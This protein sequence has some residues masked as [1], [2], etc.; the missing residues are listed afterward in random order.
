MSNSG[1]MSISQL[2]KNIRNIVE[3]EGN[4]LNGKVSSDVLKGILSKIEQSGVYSIE[5]KDEAK[6]VLA[7]INNGTLQSLNGNLNWRNVGDSFASSSVREESDKVQ[8][9]HKEMFMKNVTKMYSNARMTGLDYFMADPEFLYLLVVSGVP[10]ENIYGKIT[11]VE[12]YQLDTDNG[13]FDKYTYKEILNDENFI[14]FLNKNDKKLSDI[15]NYRECYYL[16]NEYKSYLKDWF[17][18][19]NLTQ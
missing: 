7:S 9:L 11:G 3:K 6:V 13:E 5:L 10:E 1:D 8:K 4:L 19:G 12:G 2:P 15:E 14:K 16:F 17:G 18:L